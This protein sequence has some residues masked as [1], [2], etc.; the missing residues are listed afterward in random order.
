MTTTLDP[1]KA[2]AE[3]I[4][5]C[6]WIFTKDSNDADWLRWA[7]AWHPDVNKHPAAKDVFAHVKSQHEAIKRGDYPN[8][9]TIKSKRGTFYY[10]YLAKREFELGELF[11]CNR[12][13]IWATRRSEDDLAK[14]WLDTT[15]HFKF[16]NKT[17]EDELRLELPNNSHTVANGEWAYTIIDRK[18]D[19]V[20]VRD[21][22]DKLGP[23]EPA[24]V[25]WILSRAYRLVGFL[26][27]SNVHHLD[28][29]TETFFIEPATHHGAL[30]GG[31]YYTGYGKT[32]PIGAPARTAYLR[33]KFG[34]VAQQHLTQVRAM[35]RQLLGCEKISEFRKRK[36]VG[37]PLRSWL[38]GVGGT[39]VVAEERAWKKALEDTFG[40]RRFTVC[41]ITMKE[42]YG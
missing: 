24:H 40:K 15:K 19:Y 34:S 14:R 30:L 12:H 25:A 21:A 23:F 5:A 7:K 6:R 1:V 20:R 3:E 33:G 26:N 2:T 18:R 29:S 36:D 22:L 41:P 17:V 35:G 11:I 4:L 10:P 32:P 9:V 16:P 39:D 13:V 27:Y 37:E 42:V 31:W 28:V 8:A 38:M